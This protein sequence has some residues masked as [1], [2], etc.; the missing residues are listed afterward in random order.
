VEFYL[1]RSLGPLIPAAIE[2]EVY[3][4]YL[5]CFRDPAA[6]HAACE[7]YRAGASVDLDY[8]AVDLSRKI[9]C[10]LLALWGER[11]PMHRYYDVLATW[12]E[13][14]SN[15]SGKVIPAGHFLAEENPGAVLEELAEFLKS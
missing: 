3:A 10:P 9:E 11:G 12:K 4:E 1:R 7:D 6:I 5:R 14:A 2:E 13:R 8:D 15:A